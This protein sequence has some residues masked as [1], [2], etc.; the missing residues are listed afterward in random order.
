[1]EKKQDYIDVK[2]D[3]R[4][5][6]Y[7]R[8]G[9]KKPIWQARIRVP[10]ATGYKVVSTKTEN[11]LQAQIFACN[12][13]EETYFKVKAGGSLK[14]KTFKQVFDDWEK[15]LAVMGPTRQGGSWDGT[16]G[17]IRSYA[18]GY[19]GPKSIGDI[20]AREIADYW[21][22]RRSNFA[23]KVPSAA[24]L[25]REKVC[26]IPV[27]R[28]AKQ[29]G[30]ITEIPEFDTPKFKPA[31]RSTFT[32]V[33]WREF[34]VKARAWVKEG[35]SKATGRDRFIAQQY[36][37]ILANTGMRIGEIRDLKWSDLRTMKVDDG[38]MMVA[39][40]TGKTGQR[41]VMFLPG[42]ERYV[43][44]LYDM[45]TDELGTKPGQE[46]YVI[47][48]RDG[49]QVGSLK[50]SFASLMAFSGIPSVKNGMARTIY[51]LRHFY[52]TRRLENG[53]SWFLLAKQMGTS[54]EMLHKFYE[55][56]VVT[57][58]TARDVSQGRD[59]NAPTDE[60]K[61]YPFE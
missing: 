56:L 3:G 11:L 54:V 34:Y 10:N 55:H 5:V 35:Q 37:L 41:E 40:V 58:K 2:G 8:E 1:V 4:V 30:Y 21:E 12:L 60:Q 57:E 6:L 36:F 46:E 53:T 17:R 7:K 24:T 49:G 42:A 50:K 15:S 33:E 47:C 22:W 32:E 14:S 31:R 39:T 59:R 16:V 29:K 28:Y 26:L 19:F 13:Y 44:S 23:M 52:A 18:L 43:K 45:R 25:K 9:M 48:H 27:F 61:A 20:R 38:T 51:S